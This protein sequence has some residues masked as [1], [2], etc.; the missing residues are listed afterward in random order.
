MPALTERGAVSPI[1]VSIDTWKCREP[2]EESD[3]AKYKL[4]QFEIWLSFDYI[5][6]DGNTYYSWHL[7][8]FCEKWGTIT[9]GIKVF[10]GQI[11]MVLHW[12]THKRHKASQDLTHQWWA[13]C[14]LTLFCGLQLVLSSSF[15]YSVVEV[16]VLE[17]FVE[18]QHGTNCQRR[19]TTNLLNE[20]L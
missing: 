6:P 14:E 9:T 16:P 18:L 19:P 13:F 11:R 5:G 15:Y 3:A 8:L 10:S 4:L 20:E 7:D 12:R 1:K 2:W 17:V